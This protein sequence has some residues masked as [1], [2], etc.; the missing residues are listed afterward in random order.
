MSGLGRKRKLI[1]TECQVSAMSRHKL[2][3]Q[4]PSK[5]NRHARGVPPED[6]G[7]F[8]VLG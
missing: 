3:A 5:S 1:G 8:R 2:T 7:G 6:Y 4:D